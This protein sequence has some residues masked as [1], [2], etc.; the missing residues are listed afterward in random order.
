MIAESV[1]ADPRIAP[2][3]EY[4]G[5]SSPSI[6]PGKGNPDWV[7]KGP[8]EGLFFDVTTLEDLPKHIDPELRWYGENLVVHP[9]ERPRS[10]PF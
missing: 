7:G 2:H 6:G 1:R 3:F 4:L 9:Y 10:V 5:S 8:L